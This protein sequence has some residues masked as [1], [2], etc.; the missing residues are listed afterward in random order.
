MT[1]LLTLALAV[2]A[3]VATPAAPASLQEVTF[4]SKAL[5]KPMSYRVLLPP[6]Y[7]SSARRHAVLYLL[8]GLTGSH[9]DWSDRTRLLENSG[10]LDFIIVMPDAGDSWYVNVPDAKYEDYIVQDLIADVE[11]RFR[12]LKAFHGRAIAGLSM[13]GYGALKIAF[14][15]PARFFVAGSFSG[16]V[17][18]VRDGKLGLRMYNP[19]RFEPVFGPEGSPRRT[20][21]DL[22]RLA[23]EAEPASLPYFYVDCGSEDPLLQGNREFVALLQERRIRYEYHESA[24]GH[25]WEYWD[26]RLPE[27]IRIFKKRLTP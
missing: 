22:F 6:Q 4:I 11:K 26:R 25:T 1:L 7:E 2:Q 24:G 8:H 13:G 27:F 12:A 18:I 14:R 23:R 9:I 10:T 17:E 20:E 19:E 16:A 15:F 21:N 3:A 5:G